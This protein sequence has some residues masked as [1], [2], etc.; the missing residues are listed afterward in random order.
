MKINL[1]VYKNNS[2]NNFYLVNLYCICNDRKVKFTY[3]VSTK[4]GA[5]F[6]KV[7][8]LL[9]AILLYTKDIDIIHC[10]KNIS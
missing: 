1:Y 8:F 6:L 10:K 3:S 5:N 7:I 2:T 9:N 4:L